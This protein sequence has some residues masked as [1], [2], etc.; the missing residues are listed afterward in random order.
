MDYLLTMCYPYGSYDE[1][2]LSLM[3][4]YNFKLALTT[5]PKVYDSFKHNIHEIPRLN[6]NDYLSIEW[7]FYVLMI[8]KHHFAWLENTEEFTL[9]KC[10]LIFW[11]RIIIHE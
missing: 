1:N 6:T 3:N 2:T 10:K 7:I 11:G 4:K 5:S 9:N 8:Y